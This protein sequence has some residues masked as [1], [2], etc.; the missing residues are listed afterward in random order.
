MTRNFSNEFALTAFRLRTFSGR[1]TEQ[2]SCAN[3]IQKNCSLL[4][5]KAGSRFSLPF[6]DIHRLYAV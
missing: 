4:K 1:L 2:K 3:E 5:S 6:S